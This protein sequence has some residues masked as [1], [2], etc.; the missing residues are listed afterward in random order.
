[1]KLLQ[2]QYFLAIAECGNI[3]KAAEQLYV[4]QP[5]LSK[6]MNLLE[7]ELGVKLMERQNFGVELTET[8]KEFAKDCRVV[9]AD[10]DKAVSKAVNSGRKDPNVFRIGC[11]DGAVV[12]DFLPSLYSDLKK[13]YPDMSIKLGRHTM[14]ENR[15][16]LEADEIDMLIELRFPFEKNKISYDNY[17]VKVLAQR[18][19]ALI[20]SDK[21]P[22]AK[23]KKLKL[24]DFETETYLIV[25]NARHLAVPGLETLNSLGIKNPKIEEADNFVTMMSNL[26]LGLGFCILA[27][28]VADTNPGMHA[29]PLPGDHGMEVIAV[30]KKDNQFVSSIMK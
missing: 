22:L 10:L 17:C 16:A 8:G 5:A 27:K 25:S 15:K 2:I 13:R 30:W 12:E 7:K 20:Y 21:S 3:T 14:L 4:S 18:E 1:M 19:G 29:F 26:E 23:K 6:Q 9:L 11:F 28:L 24:S